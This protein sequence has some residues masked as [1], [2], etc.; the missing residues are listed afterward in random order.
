MNPRSLTQRLLRIGV[1]CSIALTSLA[2]LA[3]PDNFGGA[4]L[5]PAQ[6]FRPAVDAVNSDQIKVRF[7][8][9]PS[10]YL[11]RNK[12]GVETTGLIPADVQLNPSALPKG[13]QKD[14]PNFGPTE[15]YQEPLDWPVQ[16][17]GGQ[18]PLTITVAVRYQGCASQGICYPPETALFPVTLPVTEP[19]AEAAPAPVA[20]LTQP[21]N[22]ITEIARSL[23]EGMLWLNLLIF[24]GAGIGQFALQGIGQ[25][26]RIKAEHTAG[27]Q[28]IDQRKTDEHPGVLQQ[29][30]N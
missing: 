1:F 17:S 25:L 22:G 10:Y 2:T 19:T 23:D 9:Q 29:A 21:A 5:P 27:Q 30:R 4:F 15:I 7:D 28:H 14:D 18:R 11:Y 6:A 12:L 24:F 16:I 13:I 20:T 8:V 26:Q 3:V